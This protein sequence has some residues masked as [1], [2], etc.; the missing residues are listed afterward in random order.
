MRIIKLKSAIALG[1]ISALAFPGVAAAHI[2]V[3]PADAPAGKT[4]SFNFVIPHGCD[5]AATTSITVKVPDSVRDAAAKSVRG[6]KA[7]STPGRM[8]WTGGPLPDHRVQKLPFTAKFYGKKNS[9][10]PLKL[11]QG[12]EGGKSTPWLQVVP[13]GAPEPETPAPVVTLTSTVKVPV[14]SSTG[15]GDGQ[16]SETN[17]EQAATND[18]PDSVD[19]DEGLAD[20]DHRDGR[21]WPRSALSAGSLLGSGAAQRTD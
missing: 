4:A 7:T 15:A 8:K 3:E 11:I 12:C 17:G 20:G 10:I 9:G 13:E 5:G 1:V 16:P 6:W 21:L 18:V 2:E 14:A 19:E